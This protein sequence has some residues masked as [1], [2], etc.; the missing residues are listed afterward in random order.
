MRRKGRT[1]PS[2]HDKKRIAREVSAGA[3]CLLH[4][5]PAPTART[6]LLELRKQ[7]QRNPLISIRGG[8]QL[9]ANGQTSRSVLQRE[10]ADGSYA[11]VIAELKALQDKGLAAKVG[12]GPRVTYRIAGNTT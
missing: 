3:L 7:L 10:V 1:G 8:R 6:N 12:S 11:R 2:A 4:E 9:R 5:T